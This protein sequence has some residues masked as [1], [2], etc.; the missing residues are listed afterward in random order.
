MFPKIGKFDGPQSSA[1]LYCPAAKQTISYLCSMCIWMES[2]GQ[3]YSLVYI[4]WRKDF[5]SL[6]NT[7]EAIAMWIRIK[8]EIVI[9]SLKFRLLKQNLSRL[10]RKCCKFPYSKGWSIGKNWFSQVKIGNKKWIDDVPL[11][12]LTCENQVQ[13]AVHKEMIM[14]IIN[15]LVHTIRH[16]TEWHLWV[17][18]HIFCIGLWKWLLRPYSHTT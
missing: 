1:W 13:C 6:Q 11:W 3:H 12:E 10:D 7:T 9:F 4:M 14:M 17:K 8:F 15:Y 16:Y 18:C 2:C 5:E